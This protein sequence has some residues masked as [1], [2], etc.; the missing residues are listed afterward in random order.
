MESIIRFDLLI[1]YAI[2][3]SLTVLVCLFLASITIQAGRT[4]KENQIFTLFCLQQVIYYLD[5]V[6]RSLISSEP[7]MLVIIRLEHLIFVFSLPLTAHFVYEIL[8]IRQRRWIVKSLYLFS[9]ILLFFNQSDLYISG[10]ED[11]FFGF[12]PRSGPLLKFLALTALLVFIYLMILLLKRSR[13]E[14][15]P[16]KKIKIRLIY[17]GFLINSLLMIG[18][19]LPTIGIDIYP[20][21]NFGFIPMGLMAYGLLRHQLLDIS[22]SWYREG[23]I[24]KALAGLFWM[25]VIAAGLFLALSKKGTFYPELLKLMVPYSLPSIISFVVCFSLASFFLFRGSR[26]LMTLLFGISCGLWGVLN[27]GMA[28]ISLLA[29]GKVAIQIARIDHFF[30][31]NQLGITVHF[32]YLL[33]NRKQRLFVYLSY[34]IGIVLTPLTLTTHFFS[35]TMYQYAFGYFVQGNWAFRIFGICAMIVRIWL[36]FLLYRAMQQQT[37]ETRRHQIFWVFWGTIVSGVLSLTAIP[38]NLGIEFYPLATFT[39][40]PILMIAYGIIKHE[41]ITIN[42]YSRKKLVGN[43]ISVFIALAY[44]LPVLICIWAL[45]IFDEEY[46]WIWTMP[47]SIPSL[48]SFIICGFLSFLCLRLGRNQQEYLLF[49]LICLLGAFL[50]MDDLLNSVI[51]DP[52]VALQIKRW[53]YFLFVFSPA[54]FVHLTLLLAKKTVRRWYIYGIYSMCIPF[55]FLSQTGGYFGGMVPFTWGFYTVRNSLFGLFSVLVLL[56]G[57]YSFVVLIKEL[58][59]TSNHFKH[60]RIL[61]I[62][63][64]LV[65]TGLLFSESF[66]TG[67]INEIYPLNRFIFI[68][69]LFFG[70]AIFHNNLKQVLHFAR[71]TLFG[72]GILLAI[73]GI[74]YIPDLV[75]P[76][77]ETKWIYFLKGGIVIVLFIFTRKI[78][79]IILSLFFEP[80]KEILEHEF[81]NLSRDLTKSQSIQDIYRKLTVLF[82]QN[83]WSSH[84]KMLYYSQRMDRFYGWTTLNGQEFPLSD[85]KQFAT[86]SDTFELESSHPC[87][88]LFKQKQTLISQEQLEEWIITDEVSIAA[89][90]MFRQTE[91]I[92]PV[93]F[94]DQLLSLLMIGSKIDDSIY[95]KGEQLFIK[96]IGLNLGPHIKNT[97]FVE[98]LEKQVEE[99]TGELEAAKF[100]AE[101]ATQAKSEFLANMSHEIRTPMN[102]ILG[103]TELLGGMVNGDQEKKHISA[104]QSSGKSLMTLINDILDLSKV[105]AGKLQLE[106]TTVNLHHVF[107]EMVVIFSKKIKDKGLEFILDIDPSLPT[108]LIL[109]E[110]RLRQVLLNLIGNAVKFTDSGYI[111]L[112]AGV[113]QRFEEENEE[114]LELVFSVEDTGTGISD[115]QQQL[116]FEAFEQQKNQNQATFG[117]T[118]LGLTITKRLIEMMG[119][120]I[121]VNSKIGKGSTF[122]VILK[123][124]LISSK[125]V[126]E[127]DQQFSIDLNRLS[128][129][130]TVI[131]TADDIAANRDLV[132]GYLEKYPIQILEASNGEEAVE[133]TNRFRPELVLM[134]IK[135]PVLDGYDATKKIKRNPDTENTVVIALTAAAIKQ[136]ENQITK[137]CDGYLKKPISQMDLVGELTKFLNHTVAEPLSPELLPSKEESD[138]KITLDNLSPDQFA[139]DVLNHF[140]ELLGQLEE[141]KAEWELLCRVLPIDSI[142]DFASEIENLGITYH[143]SPLIQW[144]KNLDSQATSFQMD[145]LPTTL[146]SFPDYIKSIKSLIDG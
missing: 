3:T 121:S 68:P 30:M 53:S 2:P 61:Y 19:I 94:E 54:L 46:I 98:G 117:G 122:Y 50:S 42:F 146:K 83:L 73:F 75:L 99:R 31:V 59:K 145:I 118:G 55:A 65:A 58:R 63:F 40:I 9:I 81:E 60:Q 51:L 85:L 114:K 132:R 67:H 135:M 142:I 66:L 103:F 87:L 1:P 86:D 82:F 47:Y 116:V 115:D 96:Q 84:F 29:D 138:D 23:F 20:P 39:F 109:D 91:F 17:F 11:H 126:Q 27:L 41:I 134:D 93:F 80:E 70:I 38:A 4:K 144:G 119:G 10:V 45:Y 57:T 18:N 49:S 136:E 104:I 77:I 28:L 15:D 102:A 111:K 43:I 35:D 108:S 21:G 100:E 69:F 113:R 76:D 101:R 123:D 141:K 25:P 124:V 90:D 64:G 44:L 88:P 13:Q 74:A 129:E 143:F 92:Q 97:R 130:P 128:F 14:S 71:S 106:Y 33:I 72:F 78:W 79:A 36:V 95:T 26:K 56:Y 112:A 110:V 16:Q 12:S 22:K 37:V 105:E 137:I 52:F 140:S 131:L 7:I 48:V 5:L 133:M 127:T 34:L 125:D 8:D 139:P 89:D 62:I 24:P 120:E 32:I 6:L 107:Q